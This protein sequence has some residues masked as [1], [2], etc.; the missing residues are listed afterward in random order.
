MCLLED[1]RNI[2]SDRG[3]LPELRIRTLRSLQRPITGPLFRCKQS[4]NSDLDKRVLWDISPLSSPSAGFL[5]KAAIPL[6]NNS[7][8]NLLG[9]CA[10]WYKSGLSNIAS[11]V[12]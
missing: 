7:S 1:Y 4:L 5:N 11:C 6:P 8:L 12:T 2:V 10:E 3:L 9:C